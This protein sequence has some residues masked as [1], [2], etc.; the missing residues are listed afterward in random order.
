M[1]DTGALVT[2]FTNIQTVR[3]LLEQGLNDYDGCV[4]FEEGGKK[5]M[6]E[7]AGPWRKLKLDE[8][9][10]QKHRR[11]T[12]YDQ[13]HT[14]GIDV[15]QPANARAALTLSKDMTFRDFAQGAYCSGSWKQTQD[16]LQ[17]RLRQIGQGQTIVLTYVPEVFDLMIRA[18][19]D[20][21]VPGKDGDDALKRTVAWLML[22]SMRIERLQYHQ[23]CIQKITNVFKKKAF[24]SLMKHYKKFSVTAATCIPQAAQEAVNVFREPARFD[25]ADKVPEQV[26]FHD[27]LVKSVKRN[28][29]VTL[30]PLVGAVSFSVSKP[31][32]IPNINPMGELATCLGVLFGDVVKVVPDASA[33][34]QRVAAADT[35]RVVFKG[36][37][38]E[39]VKRQLP[40]MA[41]ILDQTK[42]EGEQF[43][44]NHD[45]QIVQELEPPATVCQEK[46]PDEEVEEEKDT[47]V[48]RHIDVVYARDDEA[49]RRGREDS[50]RPL[51]FP[52]ALRVSRNFFNPSWVGDRRVKSPVVMVEWAP[53][54]PQPRDCA[55]HDY[56]LAD[57][58]PRVARTLSLFAPDGADSLDTAGARWH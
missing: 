55:D 49:P 10:I 57:G 8:S 17:Y 4:F 24:A 34:W 46:R 28:P 31:A 2:G 1:I 6:L 22:G 44:A 33:S 39:R 58:D 41:R 42:K 26:Y 25:I 50:K 37:D 7:R 29:L 43:R 19:D 48:P 27:V 11:F 18:T 40:L 45:V 38:L 21:G 51:A 5:M 32:D 15:P 47:Y 36:F 52:D 30:P 53:C 23:L 9:T 16:P 12:F 20:V 3:F 14:T 35:F 54:A 13:V 56:D